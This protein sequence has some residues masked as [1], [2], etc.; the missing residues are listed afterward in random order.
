M[1]LDAGSNQRADGKPESDSEQVVN[2]TG[3]NHGGGSGLDVAKVIGVDADSTK[4]C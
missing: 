2:G 3:A 4:E 1:G